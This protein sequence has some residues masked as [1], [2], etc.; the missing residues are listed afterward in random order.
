MKFD[1]GP[2]WRRRLRFSSFMV[3]MVCGGCQSAP[4]ASETAMEES[5]LTFWQAL[6]D[7]NSDARRLL[8]ELER[9][10]TIEDP[11]ERRD[12]WELF[13]L[14]FAANGRSLDRLHKASDDISD[15]LRLEAIEML[16]ALRKIHLE[17][18][19]RRASRGP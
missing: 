14:E 7:H 6:L 8:L 17:L 16:S 4:T 1:A 15:R 2:S 11:Q 10:D 13:D 12:A 3:V 9:I 19:M 18:T 5:D